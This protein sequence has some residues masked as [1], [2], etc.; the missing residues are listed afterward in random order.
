MFAPR[1]VL[2]GLKEYVQTRMEQME[3]YVTDAAAFQQ[4]Y[5][6]T[7]TAGLTALQEK[8]SKDAATVIDQVGFDIKQ[9]SFVQWFV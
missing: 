7:V 9:W 4:Q 3:T 2:C 6:S 1:S 5:I 8:K